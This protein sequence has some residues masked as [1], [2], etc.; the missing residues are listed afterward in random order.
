MQVIC[1][2]P[3]NA[4]LVLVIQDRR[5]VA[6]Y[7]R[8]FPKSGRVA[9]K[10]TNADLDGNRIMLN[11]SVSFV[12]RVTKQMIPHPPPHR[13][14]TR[15]DVLETHCSVAE[16]PMIWKSPPYGHSLMTGEQRRYLHSPW[17]SALTYAHPRRPGPGGLRD[18]NH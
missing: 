1:A 14:H 10:E 7:E 12:L 13:R 5:D 16:S 3:H 2:I 17:E 18:R 4:P 11:K 8:T 6:L 9:Q 15:S